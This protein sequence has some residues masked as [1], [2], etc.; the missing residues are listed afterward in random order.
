MIIY[1]ATNKVN[2]KTYVGQTSRTLEIRMNDHKYGAFTKYKDRGIYF[3][4]A[5]RKYGWDTFE[6]EIID[7]AESLKELNEKEIQWISYYG[8]YLNGYNMDIGGG[9]RIG[10]THT[11]IAKQRMS[12][13]RKKSIYRPIGEHL[14]NIRKASSKPKSDEHKRNIGK[15]QAGS[16]NHQ[17][18]L[19][20]EDVI[21]IKTMLRDGLTQARI[22][23]TYGVTRDTIG[24]IKRGDRWAHVNIND[25]HAG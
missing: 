8:S 24:K 12:D 1:K 14:E 9:N 2:G 5:I 15:A 23:K 25:A 19:T 16:K 11:D 22:A 18:V 3:Y 17:S 13:E 7:T 20:E 4:H 10:F 6:W 21:Q